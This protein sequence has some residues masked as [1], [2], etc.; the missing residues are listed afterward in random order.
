MSGNNEGNFVCFFFFCL[1]VW[2]LFFVYASI[3]LVF[4]ALCGLDFVWEF[5]RSIILA[6]RTQAAKPVM[7]FDAFVAFVACINTCSHCNCSFLHKKYKNPT[8]KNTQKLPRRHSAKKNCGSSFADSS[9]FHFCFIGTSF[10]VGMCWVQQQETWAHT[11]WQS[12]NLCAPTSANKVNG[13]NKQMRQHKAQRLPSSS[14][15]IR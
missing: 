10:N 15:Q 7:A 9:S 14:K 1:F 12:L 13:A 8:L 4:H 5:R 11:S 3:T 2:F 6:K